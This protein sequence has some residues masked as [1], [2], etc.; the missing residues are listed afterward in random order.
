[1]E[2]PPET[3]VIEM[4]D[5]PSLKGEGGSLA[6]LRI[7]EQLSQRELAS[8]EQ[9]LDKELNEKLNQLKGIQ[10]Q[11]NQM[12]QAGK[13]LEENNQKLRQ[14]N[15]K[16]QKEM[17]DSQ[18]ILGRVNESLDKS[19]N[20]VWKTYAKTKGT[21]QGQPEHPIKATISQS[22]QEVNRQLKQGQGLADQLLEIEAGAEELPNIVEA[23]PDIQQQM[24]SL[25]ALLTGDKG[26]LDHLVALW[27]GVRNQGNQQLSKDFWQ[28]LLQIY[29]NYKS[30]FLVFQ[31]V[32]SDA[33]E[34]DR[35]NAFY[36]TLV[37]FYRQLSYMLS[38]FV[39][40]LS[41]GE[42]NQLQAAIN[43]L[44]LSVGLTL[45][46]GLP[47]SAA[48]IPPVGAF[49][50]VSPIDLPTPATLVPFSAFQVPSL[51]EEA[52][53]KGQ[54]RAQDILQGAQQLFA[55]RID[56]DG[57]AFPPLTKSERAKVVSQ[58]SLRDLGA[59]YVEPL[60]QL[61]QEQPTFATALLRS[62]SSII[63]TLP[64]DQQVEAFK[65]SIRELVQQMGPS[66]KLKRTFEQ[67]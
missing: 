18:K 10:G 51:S 25:T 56:I 62:L 9:F 2:A 52:I 58:Q 14:R 54:E 13:A 37:K 20:R 27:Y 7:L 19:V 43:D 29:Q 24:D 57:P 65:E 1:M 12:I 30:L 64:E 21:L 5:Q 16:L 32:A 31:P 15:D 17:E 22:I 49:P 47:K 36:D 8:I 59:F 45:E 48:P 26:I 42:I 66:K 50:D 6:A 53:Q 34:A 38:S 4:S 35:I 41:Q 60:V 11:Y 23:N 44:A 46:T 67:R 33:V 55:S 40:D 39:N 63:N 28:K 3:P 61:I